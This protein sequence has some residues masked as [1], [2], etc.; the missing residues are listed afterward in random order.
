[1]HLI[2]R[3]RHKRQTSRLVNC[4]NELL[5]LGC[6]LR[7]RPLHFDCQETAGLGYA[8]D[9]V[10][11]TS[12]VSRDAATIRFSNARVLMLAAGD[13]AKAEVVQNLFF[14]VLFDK[15]RLY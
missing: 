8:T 15:G 2:N 10:G 14:D 6:Q 4:V 3:S 5:L 9:D 11:H 7:S 13:S 1:M 12:G